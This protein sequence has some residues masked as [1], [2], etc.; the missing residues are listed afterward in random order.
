M[1]DDSGGH[2][3]TKVRYSKGS[4]STDDSGEQLCHGRDN[5]PTRRV[6]AD[7]LATRA[8]RGCGAEHKT[9]IRR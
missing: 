3:L 8:C 6:K 2:S 9:D 4:W 5:F 1:L 7:G